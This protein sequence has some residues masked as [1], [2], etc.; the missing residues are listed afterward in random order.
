MA[1]LIGN[2][3]KNL[4][5]IFCHHKD[6]FSYRKYSDFDFIEYQIC[7]SCGRILNTIRGFDEDIR[8]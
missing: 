4:K 8:G 6:A 3:I 5:K 2:M 1:G 7:S